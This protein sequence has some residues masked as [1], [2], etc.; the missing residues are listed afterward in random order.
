ML[1]FWPSNEA[2]NIVAASSAPFGCRPHRVL[3]WGRRVPASALSTWGSIPQ[4]GN[5]SISDT[6]VFAC[7]GIEP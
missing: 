4:V 2:A 1:T 7:Q 5:T 3:T 6:Y